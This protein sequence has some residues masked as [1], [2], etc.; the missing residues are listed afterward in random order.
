MARPAWHILTGEY[1][2]APG[3]VSDY[4]RSV[5]MGLA[6][7]NDEVHVWAPPVGGDLREDPGVRVH[8]LPFAYGPRGLLA[9]SRA[10]G[11]ERSP[12]R[13]LVQYVP[14]AFGLRGVNVP[15]C[16][17]LASVQD[18]E[19]FVL[20]HEVAVPWTALRRWKWNAAAVAM[21]A[22]AALLLARADR[23]FIST[24]SWEPTLRSL[25]IG[26]KGATWLPVPSNVPLRPPEG[27]GAMIR[28]RLGIDEGVPVIGH[29]GTYG[30]L[31]A[32]LLA[33]ALVKLLEMDSRRVVLL[34][35]RGGDAFAPQLEMGAAVRGRVFATGALD[36][37]EVAGHLLAC[38]VLVQPYPDG[39]STRRTTA[40]AGLGLGVAVATNDGHLTE[41]IWRESGAVELVARPDLVAAAAT[42]LLEDP[43]HAASVAVRGRRLYEERFSLE[44]VVALLRA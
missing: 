33:P 27:A 2:P 38:D 20:F 18:T 40:M 34:V 36:A 21:N 22:M 8:P 12:R 32:P 14:H 35:G 44:R 5:A 31:T 3:G 9:L 37:S 39:V 25:A 6:A 41:P 19:I 10:L 1:P 7:V 17:W 11:R 28:A 16:A 15:F 4:T 23:V 13:I 43:A 24:T 29:F 42:R 30:S 26:W